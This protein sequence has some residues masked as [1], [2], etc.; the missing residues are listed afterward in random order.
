[1]PALPACALQA[2]AQAEKQDLLNRLNN[3]VAQ[4][5]AAREEALMLDA[6]L[7]Q[8]QDDMDSGRLQPAGGMAAA[9][10]AAAA[11]GMA[12]P[13]SGAAGMTD[14]G[15]MDRMRRFMQQ[16]PGSSPM[17]D[18]T[19]M[20]TPSGECARLA[21]LLWSDMAGQH[22]LVLAL[23]HSE[24]PQLCLCPLCCVPACWLCRS[25]L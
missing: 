11:A 25:H 4:R 19:P 5:N 12:T 22:E 16:I 23:S 17:R 24:H 14:E 9:A 10:A 1:L 20:A 3:A 6:K 8:M 21:L 13:P 15:M 2:K 7:K 18:G